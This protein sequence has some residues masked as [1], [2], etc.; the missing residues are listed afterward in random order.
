MSGID[1][2]TISCMEN[3]GTKPVT[4]T[5]RNLQAVLKALR[6]HGVEMGDDYVKLT[7]RRR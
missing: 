4:A 6:R 2:A 3:C 5:S 7:K 1:A